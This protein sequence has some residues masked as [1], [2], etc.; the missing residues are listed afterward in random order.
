[1]KNHTELHKIIQSPLDNNVGKGNPLLLTRFR[2]S[3]IVIE[4]AFNHL[5]NCAT[6]LCEHPGMFVDYALANRNINKMVNINVA[7]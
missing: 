7:K 2:T 1:M 5:P 4:G 6:I 3:E